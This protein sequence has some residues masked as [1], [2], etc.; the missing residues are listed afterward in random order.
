LTP[1]QPSNFE[2]HWR[3]ESNRKGVPLEGM[4]GKAGLPRTVKFH[5][6][7]HTCATRLGELGVIEEVRAAILGHGKRGITQHYTHATLQ[8][9]R[10]AVEAYEQLLVDDSLTG[11]T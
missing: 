1:I 10:R 8:A 9:M 6:L 4:R 3:G 5:H 11:C 7:R 2:R